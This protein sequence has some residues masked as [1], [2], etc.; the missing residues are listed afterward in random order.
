MT[1]DAIP[2]G[3]IERAPLD[4]PAPGNF[5]SAAEREA[6]LRQV[7]ANA[8]VQIGAYDH[9]IVRWFAEYADWPT[10]AVIT[11]WIK[12]AGQRGDR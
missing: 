12:R 7:L 5:P 6:I 3:P 8:G 9:L 4:Y 10:F 1:T 11:S 2:G